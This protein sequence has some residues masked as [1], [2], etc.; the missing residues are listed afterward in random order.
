M[1]QIKQLFAY[2]YNGTYLNSKALV[3][4]QGVVA[5]DSTG[6]GTGRVYTGGAGYTGRERGI[7]FGGD[8]NNTM[9]GQTN[10]IS[11]TGVLGSDV[12][13]TGTAR[14]GTY[15]CSYGGDKAIFAYGYSR[16]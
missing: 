13:A 16:L 7:V 14:Y 15:Q 8:N 3:S 9:L 5:S 2:G 1:V 10:L 4:N 11:N 12:S 6:A